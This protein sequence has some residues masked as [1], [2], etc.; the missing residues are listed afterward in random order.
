MKVTLHPVKPPQ[1]STKSAVANSEG[2]L[3]EKVVHE[4]TNNQEN[5]DPVDRVDVD[6][7]QADVEEPATY[8]GHVYSIASMRKV[9]ASP[10]CCCLSLIP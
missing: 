9:P 4:E 3:K 6:D 2:L 1:K 5:Q 10:R 8:V 7:D